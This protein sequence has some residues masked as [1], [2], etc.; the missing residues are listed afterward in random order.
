MAVLGA[1]SATS[2][3]VATLPPSAPVMPTVNASPLV[4]RLDPATT[5]ALVPEVESPT[6]TSPGRQS[7]S[8]WR[9]KISSKAPSLATAVSNAP[10]VVSAIE[11]RPGRSTR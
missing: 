2:A 3:T 4:G 10:S 11:A 5:F 8:S 7:A 6:A 9:A 1:R